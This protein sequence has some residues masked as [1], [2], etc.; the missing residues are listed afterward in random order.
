MNAQLDRQPWPVVRAW[1]PHW[2]SSCRK[3]SN[4]LVRRGEAEKEISASQKKVSRDDD[5]GGEIKTPVTFVVS[6]V[7][8]KN[9]SD[10]PRCQFVGCFGI[11]IRIADTTEHAQ[12]LIGGSDSIE[13]EVWASRA[14]RLGG[15]VVQQI[16]GGVEPFYPVASWNRSLKKQGA[17]HI[18][19]G[20]EDGFTVLRRNVGTS[21]PQK[22]TLLVAKNAREEA[23]SNSQ[24]LSH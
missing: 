9:T 21:H 10:E 24:P 3:M 13:D 5:V 17:Q 4:S 12:V 16:C 22:K 2:E 7:S 18:I 1:E 8:E 14:D 20:V 19:N 23:L 6:R 15:E 11:E